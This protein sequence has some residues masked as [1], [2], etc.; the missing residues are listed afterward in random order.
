MFLISVMR[1]VCYYTFNRVRKILFFV[2]FQ[3]LYVLS[4]WLLIQV[5]FSFIVKES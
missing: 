1:Q 3:L 4:N 2:I 5:L